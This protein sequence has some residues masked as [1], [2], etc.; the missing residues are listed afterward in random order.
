MQKPAAATPRVTQPHPLLITCRHCSARHHATVC[1]TCK[2]P[3]PS[4][5]VIRG[6]AR[7]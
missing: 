5:I 6:M 4:F 2:A 1:P 3:T 7:T